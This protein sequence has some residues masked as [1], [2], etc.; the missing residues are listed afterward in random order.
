[1]SDPLLELVRDGLRMF[2]LGRPLFVGMP[3]SPNHPQ[4][5]HTF[6]RRHGDKMRADGGSAAND[7]LVMGTHVGTHIDSLAHVSH[8]GLLHGGIDARE[9]AVGG[10]F[11][12][13]GVHTIAPVIR[14]G[15]L[16][17]VPRVLGVAACEA[18]YEI[19]PADLDRAVER[20]NV[21]IN[22]GDVVLVRS[23]WGQHFDDGAEVY[24]GAETGVP[25]VGE[26][27]A[28]W[29]ARHEV[30]AVGADT[31]AFEQLAPQKGHALLPAHRVLLVE[32]G[33]YIV[34]ALALEELSAAEVFTFTFILIPLNLIGATG[35]PVRP[36][37]VVTGD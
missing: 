33:I 29:L 8:N 13:L 3:Q 30:F 6:P 32:S 26:A 18:A 37:A 35:S 36:L 10:K 19:T 20:Q 23:G 5:W 11:L 31:I 25:G 34:E 9:A 24:V 15:V 17:D 4:F 12:E 28:K 2:D 14:R 16:L 1:M 7:M 21:E 27:G 22:P